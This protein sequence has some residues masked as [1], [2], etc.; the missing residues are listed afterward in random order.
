MLY[1]YYIMISFSSCSFVHLFSGY[2]P[3][4][5]QMATR[6][7]LREVVLEPLH[8]L[9]ALRLEEAKGFLGDWELLAK[10]L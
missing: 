9:I 7:L 1:D 4:I 10:K 8:A 2:F 6:H 3:W 5:F